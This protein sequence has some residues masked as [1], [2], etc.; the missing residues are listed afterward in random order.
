MTISNS[1]PD[2]AT[3]ILVAGGIA[4]IVLS[5]VLGWVLSAKR[6]K[7]PMEPHRWLLI[8]HEVSLQEGVLLLGI[9]FALQFTELP[10]TWAATGAGLLV[11]ASLF[12]DLSGVVNWLRRTHDQFQERSVGWVLASINAVMNTVG[13]A[14]VAVGVVRGLLR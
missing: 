7:G 9:A 2:T 6:M 5:Y 4:N 8:A 11:A 13:L 10:P 12:Q 14:I 3:A 1:A